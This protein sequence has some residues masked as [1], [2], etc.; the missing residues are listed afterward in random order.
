MLLDLNLLSACWSKVV[1]GFSINSKQMQLRQ[2]SKTA[3][4]SESSHLFQLRNCTLFDTS[5]LK[6]QKVQ[7]SIVD[8]KVVIA[9]W[10]N[11]SYV[12][13]WKLFHSH[14]GLC[15]NLC[16]SLYLLSFTLL[17]S[18]PQFTVFKFW[19]FLCSFKLFSITLLLNIF[20]ICN[21]K[22]LPVLLAM[23]SKNLI[24]KFFLPALSAY[25]GPWPRIPSSMPHYLLVLW[26]DPF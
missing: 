7:Y 17:V 3:R 18:I 10:R 13:L 1:H 11:Y 16:F 4:P 21:N 9:I 15:W 8:A 6:L 20:F 5:Q 23:A 2:L 19:T 12:V 24:A 25:A 14:L 22:Q 26:S